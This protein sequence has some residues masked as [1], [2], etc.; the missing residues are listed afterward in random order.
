MPA[1]CRMKPR[2]RVRPISPVPSWAWPARTSRARRIRPISISSRTGRGSTCARL[3]R[4][5]EP[6]DGLVVLVEEAGAEIRGAAAV[7]DGGTDD[8]AALAQ[9]EALRDSVIDHALAIVV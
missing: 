4:H 2:L 1:S 3:W 6:L 7:D 9:C 8:V 5:A